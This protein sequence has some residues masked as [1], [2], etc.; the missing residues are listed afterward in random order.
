[1]AINIG[2]VRSLGNTDGLQVTPDDRQQLVK[3]V[4]SAGVA[5]VAV[6]DNGVVANGEVISLSAVFSA[7]DYVTLSG[8]WTNRTKVTVVLDDGSTISNARIVI[9]NVQYYDNM[10]SSFKLVQLEV[11]RI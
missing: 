3:T 9:K 4:T 1:M 2:T 8:Y 6:E 7:A 10:L 5:S 11:W